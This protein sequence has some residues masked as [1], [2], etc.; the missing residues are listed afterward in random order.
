M[1]NGNIIEYNKANPHIERGALVR[2]YESGQWR[3]ADTYPQVLDIV[4][5][6][7]YLHSFNPSIVHGD[8]KGV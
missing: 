1:E 8:L 5:G 6:L 7:D 2:H 3:D 4:R